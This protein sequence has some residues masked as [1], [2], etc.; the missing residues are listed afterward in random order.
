MSVGKY[1]PT[2]SSS[3]AEDQSWFEKNGG[4]FGNGI[5]PSS[6]YDDQGYDSY[7][8]NGYT[9]RDRA[10]YTESQYLCDSSVNDYDEC[11]YPTYDHV[12]SEW[13]RINILEM[14]EGIKTKIEN[15]PLFAFNHNKHVS[16]IKIHDDAFTAQYA[17]RKVLDAGGNKEAYAVFDKEFQLFFGDLVE[18]MQNH[19]TFLEEFYAEF[20]EAFIKMRKA[21]S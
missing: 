9:D 17:L 2:V 3:Y 10:G 18:N 14:S 7:G 1:S 19:A 5:L 21:M 8:Y 6:Q 11:S 15:D 4:G 12:S 20:I 16:L 13:S